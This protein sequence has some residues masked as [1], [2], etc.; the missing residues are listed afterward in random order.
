MTLTMGQCGSGTYTNVGKA[1]IDYNLNGVFD[2]PAELLG[3]VQGATS[4]T[5]VD[6]TFNFEVPIGVDL[7]NT[8]LRVMQRETSDPTFVTPC[9]TYSWGSVHDYNVDITPPPQGFCP[10]P[11]NQSVANI[12]DQGAELQWDHIWVESFFDVFVD[13]DLPGNPPPQPDTEPTAFGVPGNSL[14]WTEGQPDTPYNW[15]VR[16][17]CGFDNPKVDNFWVALDPIGNLIPTLSGGTMDDPGEDGTWY[18]YDQAPGQPWYNIWFYND[19]LDTAKIKKIRMGFW[20]QTLDPNFPGNLFYV[21]NWSNENWISYQTPPT[22]SAFPMP[23]QEAFIERSPVNGPLQISP[24]MQW[25]ELYYVIR[26]YNPEWISIDLWGD[27]I[28]IEQQMTMPPPPESPLSEWW[29]PGMHGGIIVHECLPESSLS[30]WTGPHNFTTAGP[31][32]TAVP[33]SLDFGYVP[34][35]TVS[36]SQPYNLSGEWMQPGPVTIVAPPGFEV[37]LDDISFGPQAVYNNTM[38]SFNIPVYVHF[39][40]SG[41]PADYTGDIT[42]DGSGTSLLLPVTGSSIEKCTHEVVMYD[43]FGDGWNGGYI[44]ISINGVLLHP[45]VTLATGAGPQSFYFQAAED[46]VIDIA[47][48]DGGWAYECF[49][50]VYGAYENLLGS[51][52]VGGVVP[53]GLTGLLASCSCPE[54]DNLSVTYLSSTEVELSWTGGSMWNVEIGPPGFIPGTNTS[55][56]RF[57][58]VTDLPLMISDLTSGQAYEF[59][60][61]NDCGFDNPKVDNFWVGLDITG[62]LDPIISGGTMDD[63]GETGTWYLYDQGPGQ[64]WWN[65]WFYND[66]L[67]LEKIKKMRVGFWVEPWDPGVPGNLEYVFNWSNEFWISYQIPPMLSAFPMP[68]DELYIMRSPVNGPLQITAP[69]WVELYFTIDDFNPEWVSIDLWGDNIFID[70][71]GMDPPPPASP[72][73]EWWFPGMHGGI[74]V[75]ECLPETSNSGWSGPVPIETCEDYFIDV[76]DAICDN[77]FP[78]LW[79]GLIIN[80]GGN[81]VVTYPTT[82]PPGCDSTITLHLTVHPTY[83]FVT[84]AEICDNETY[85]WR[86]NDYSTAGT[87]NDNLL[88]QYGCDSV[89]VLNLTVHPTY[90]FTENADICEGD[91]YLWHGNN[92]NL[93]GTYYDSL[94]TQHGC[95]SVYILNLNVHPHY[96]FVTDAEICDNQTYTWRGNDYSIAGTYY[97]SFLSQYGCD[98]VYVLNLTVKPTYL[99]VTDTTIWDYQFPFEWED[100]LYWS[101]GTYYL[102]YTAANGC[103]SILQ[104]NLTSNP[105]GTLWVNKLMGTAAQANWSPISGVNRYQVRYWDIDGGGMF[106]YVVRTTMLWRKLVR[107]DTEY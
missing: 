63:P 71:I 53:T 96:E 69:T 2:D 48:T 59:Y 106:V 87:Y 76:Y 52:G 81:H 45:G 100:G 79:E 28:L 44:D 61:Q 86:G 98:S 32:L 51:D 17:D 54:P 68:A 47:W 66:P 84:N 101:A 6:Y 56:W 90:E 11:T 57:D 31:D 104:L 93:A 43:D 95:D 64:P 9:V 103:D 5:G 34:A 42:N 29:I 46:D 24:G 20:V 33:G 94:L 49:Y 19:P 89:Y 25:V 80:Q 30:T 26:D 58:G 75:H 10:P 35:G 37:S 91:D 102:T 39:V 18:L 70:P 65:I 107:S 77:E 105:S 97:D 1:W 15:W 72:M 92:Y 12:T 55:N 82:N 8:R 40:P 16:T 83:E 78:Y 67:D 22:F 85:S 13:I 73:L 38:P 7:G 4:S 21:F 3:V 41:P 36:A 99:T 27:N 74:L 88:S 60:V 23:V 62:T 14:P 50:Y